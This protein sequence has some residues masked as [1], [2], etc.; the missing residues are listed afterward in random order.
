MKL[1]AAPGG[2]TSHPSHPT[3]LAR[4][5]PHRAGSVAAATN[6]LPVDD[7]DKLLDRRERKCAD[8]IGTV[9]VPCAGR[10]QCQILICFS[11]TKYTEAI[12]LSNSTR[13]LLWFEITKMRIAV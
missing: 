4:S 9:P 11:V 1:V 12:F 13:K 10:L 2:V 7:V 3:S 8:T 5:A 6:E